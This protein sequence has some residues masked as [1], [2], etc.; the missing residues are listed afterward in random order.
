MK[1][2]TYLSLAAFAVALMFSTAI[3]TTICSNDAFSFFDREDNP[4][5]KAEIANFLLAD[6]AREKK[7]SERTAQQVSKLRSLTAEFTL[8][9]SPE[10]K[11]LYVKELDSIAKTLHDERVN[12]DTSELPEDVREAWSEFTIATKSNFDLYRLG[13]KSKLT[14]EARDTLDKEVTAKGEEYR[15]VVKKYGFDL[16]SSFFLIDE[17]G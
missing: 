4:K 5:A 14:L 11:N 12:A 8:E 16:V 7:C 17:K 15:R 6:K 2:K 9:L 1:N 10:A 13:A 3:V